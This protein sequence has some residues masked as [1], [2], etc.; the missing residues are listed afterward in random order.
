MP[1]PLKYTGLHTDCPFEVAINKS[2][3][4]CIQNN[5]V[6]PHFP[7][8]GQSEHIDKKKLFSRNEQDNSLKSCM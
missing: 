8:D 1:L 4:R 3:R 5:S 2:R 6:K 7:L